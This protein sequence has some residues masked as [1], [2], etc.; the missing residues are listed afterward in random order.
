MRFQPSCLL[1]A[2]FGV[3]L[4]RDLNL[5]PAPVSRTVKER[6]ELDLGDSFKEKDVGYYARC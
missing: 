5:P 4:Q 1:E 2:V 6:H 3:V